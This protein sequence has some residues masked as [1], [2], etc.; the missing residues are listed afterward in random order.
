MQELHVPFLRLT[1]N[2][3]LFMVFRFM[4]MC[5]FQAVAV[6]LIGRYE[7]IDAF[8]QRGRNGENV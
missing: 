6:M 5:T 1:Q 4:F 2:F 7:L 3:W 8:A